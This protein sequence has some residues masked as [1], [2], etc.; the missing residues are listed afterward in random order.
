MNNNKNNPNNSI[1]ISITNIT[2]NNSKLINKKSNNNSVNN[3]KTNQ[4]NRYQKLL[5]DQKVRS[6]ILRSTANSVEKKN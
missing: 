3:N 1:N 4:P 5:L 6:N 2:I